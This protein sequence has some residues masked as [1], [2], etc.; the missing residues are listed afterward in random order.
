[1]RPTKSRTTTLAL[2]S[3]VCVG[4]AVL[5]SATSAA[6][7][8]KRA[9]AADVAPATFDSVRIRIRHLLDSTKAPSLA[10][11]VAKGGKIIWEEGFG[12]ADLDKHVPSTPATLYSMASISKP[13][14]ATGLMKLVERGKIDLDRPAN[15]YLGTARIT[16]LAGDA[17]DATVRRVLSHTAGLPLHYRFFYDGNPNVRPSMDEAIS[18]Y[19][20][21]V[22]PPG[23]VFNYS[24]LG[25]GVIEEIIARAAGRSYEEYMRT[26]VFGPLGMP[27][28]TISTGRGLDHAATRYDAKLKPVAFYDF[29]HRGASAVY[30]SADE[31]LRFGMFHLHDHVRGQARVLSDTAIDAMQHVSTPGDTANGY[32]LGWAINNDNGYHRVSHTGGMPG[33]ATVL[34]LYP[35]EDVAIVVLGNQSNGLPGLVAREIA[36]VVLGPTYA[37]AAAASR[38]RDRTPVAF[39]APEL[40]GE[41]VGSVRTY[42][43]TVPLVLAVKSDIVSVK[44]GADS[45]SPRWTELTEATFRNKQLDG[46]FAGTIPTDDARLFPHVIRISLWL[47]EGTLRGWAAAVATNDPV[48]GAVSSYVELTRAK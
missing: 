39:V 3:A 44:F 28:S 36:S 10:V 34:N 14:T 6:Q 24:N 41:W 23:K 43:G 12:Y 15:D 37:A 27:H 48:A 4:A 40:T 8:A 38:T 7:A 35:T 18:R 30:T 42:R 47:D 29:D 25:F 19:A 33:V 32:G 45:T 5:S 21:V 13:I 2:L 1:M 26:E 11:A 17:S 9:S 20:I 16:G 31:L 22:Y 46:Q